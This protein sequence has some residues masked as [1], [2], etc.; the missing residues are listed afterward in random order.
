MFEH[1]ENDR[2]VAADWRPEIHD[3]DGLALWT[4]GGEWLWR[5]LANP[6][7]LRFNAHLDA[8]P[9]GFGLLQRDR[10]FD[11]YQDDGAFYDRRPSVWIEP[12]SGWGAGSVHLVELPTPDETADNIVAY[13]N[14]A[15]PP[16]AG[17]ELLYSYRVHWGSA[18]PFVPPL[19]QVVATRTGIGGV[20]GR[21]RLHFSWRFVVDFAGGPLARLPADARVQPIVSASRGEVEIPSAR[22]LAAVHGYRAIFD[23]RPEGERSERGEPINIRLYLAADGQALSE[24][25]LYQWTPPTAAELRALGY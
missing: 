18:L 3:S 15:R 13:W 23:L 7:R 16:Q 2:R 24:T 14:P 10:S 9:R 1:G 17:E 4:G 20:I 6:A 11:H 25:W 21:P 12:R 5:P 22:P 19:A 8:D